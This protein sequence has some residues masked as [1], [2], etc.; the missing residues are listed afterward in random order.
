MP[1]VIVRIPILIG[2]F[3]AAMRKVWEAAV[4]VS[5]QNNRIGGWRP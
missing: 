4:H 1:V 2:L 3:L 5:C